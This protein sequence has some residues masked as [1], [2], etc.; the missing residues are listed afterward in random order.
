MESFFLAPLL[1]YS[2]LSLH[3]QSI[4]MRNKSITE[5]RKDARDIFLAG[6]QAVEPVNAIKRVVKR[7]GKPLDVGGKRY[8][9]DQFNRVIVVGAG[10]AGA[11]MAKAIEDVLGDKI[12]QGHVNVKYG[13]LIK[14][15]LLILKER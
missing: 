13:H 15:G 12:I 2:I 3:I 8:N 11:P 4:S 7:S 14:N 5:L 10:K 1:H 9:L 6:L